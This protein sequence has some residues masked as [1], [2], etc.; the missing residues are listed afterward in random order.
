[1]VFHA[2]KISASEINTNEIQSTNYKTIED[3]PTKVKS[4]SND[5]KQTNLVV[6][7]N[8]KQQTTLSQNNSLLK[9]PNTSNDIKTQTDKQSIKNTKQVQR[10]NQKRK[11]I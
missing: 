11:I 1:M 4:D 6:E 2:N 5:I 7:K 3:I 9:Q 10:I 8:K